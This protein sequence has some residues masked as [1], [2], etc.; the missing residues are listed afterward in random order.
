MIEGHLLGCLSIYAEWQ[1]TQ[2]PA[3]EGGSVKTAGEGMTVT[4]IC[5]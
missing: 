2:L 3:Q 4:R 5:K 1:L